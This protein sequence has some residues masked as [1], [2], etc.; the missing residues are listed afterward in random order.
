MISLIIKFAIKTF[1][2]IYLMQ[3][4]QQIKGYWQPESAHTSPVSSIR[5]LEEKEPKHE[6]LIEK[7]MK[8]LI[9]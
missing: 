4:M 2:K 6:S 1:N 9:K 7:C 5:E 3:K 8:S